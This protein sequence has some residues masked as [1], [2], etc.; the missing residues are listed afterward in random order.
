MDKIKDQS[1]AVLKYAVLILSS[2]VA[3]YPFIWV[4]LSSLKD[5]FEIYSNSFGLPQAYQWVNYYKAWTVGKFGVN[6]INSVLISFI[7][8]GV[9][10]IISAMVSYSIGRIKPNNALYT[11]F[12]IGIMIPL[13]ALLIP[14]FILIKNMGIMN[15][16]LSLYL[17]YSATNI[18]MS[19]FILVS[20]IKTIPS[21]LD[22]AAL[23]EGMNFWQIFTKVIFPLSKPGLATI[24]T[25]AFLN[26][27]N[28][29]VYA[30]VLIAKPAFKTLPLGI[31]SLKGQ[32]FTDYSLMCAGLAITIVPVMIFYILF[33]EQVIKG[34][35]AGAVK[36]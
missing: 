4:I 12:T 16:R 28:E 11:F 30:A 33:Q 21:A 5:N 22:E 8:T 35:T 14:T 15:T 25:L 2:L 24:G 13:H 20:F 1:A 34:M 32:Y 7:S 26:C 17:V 23:I 31:A 10:V 6:F 18:S 9:V 19:V 27:W 3:L 29:Y 36:G